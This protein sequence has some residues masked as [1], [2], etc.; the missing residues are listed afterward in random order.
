MDRTILRTIRGKL[1]EV[2]TKKNG[3]IVKGKAY[4]K[5]KQ[6]NQRTKLKSDINAQEIKMLCRTAST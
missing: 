4:K 3:R 6:N 5:A 1:M 2:D